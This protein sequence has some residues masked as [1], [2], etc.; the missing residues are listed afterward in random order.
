M[1]SES[2]EY[3]VR[4]YFQ[5]VEFWRKDDDVSLLMQL[6]AIPAPAPLPV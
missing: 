6:G 5:I 4:T 1:T 2:N 3:T